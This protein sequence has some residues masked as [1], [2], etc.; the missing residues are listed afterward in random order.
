MDRITK[1]ARLAYAFVFIIFGCQHFI[2][3]SFTATLVPSWIPWHLF[4][5]YFT[6]LAMF[7][8]A[9]SMIIDRMT[10]AAGILLGSMILLF[11]LLVHIP[12]LTD[13]HW[14]GG[15]ITNAC[16]DIGLACGAFFIA[17]QKPGDP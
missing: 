16:K 13:S 12:M 5:T 3:A 6:A 9:I 11:V 15:K 14:A 17:G 8:A 2:Y 7:A 10:R 4:W 1:T